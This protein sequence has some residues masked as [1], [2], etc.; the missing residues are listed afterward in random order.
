MHITETDCTGC[1]ACVAVCPVQAISIHEQ[2][3]APGPR[4]N[5]KGVFNESFVHQ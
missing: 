2:D 4:P 5:S 3:T 1:G